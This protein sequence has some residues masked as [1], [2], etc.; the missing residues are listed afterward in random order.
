MEKMNYDKMF[1]PD[2][3]QNL[4]NP[5]DPIATLRP[6]IGLGNPTLIEPF[7]AKIDMLKYGGDLLSIAC[8]EGKRDIVELFI[9]RGAD[10]LSP[11]ERV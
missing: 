1:T 11:P 7:L 5:R 3:L 4:M 2:M 9:T 6:F 8:Q 10:I